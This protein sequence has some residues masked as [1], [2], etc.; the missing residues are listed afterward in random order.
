MALGRFDRE[1]GAR[2]PNREEGRKEPLGFVYIAPPLST[3]CFDWFA[4]TAGASFGASH[5]ESMGVEGS[6][7]RVESASY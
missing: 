3:V 5:G 1:G 2:P 6:K 4:G 7:K